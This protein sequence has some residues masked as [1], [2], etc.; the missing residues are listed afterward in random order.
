MHRSAPKQSPER[1]DG[2]LS[3]FLVDRDPLRVFD[4]RTNLVDSVVKTANSDLLQPKLGQPFSLLAVGGYG[5]RELFPHS[6]IDLLA[7]V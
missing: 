4:T 3:Q 1:S 7:V 2:L 6:D 5:R